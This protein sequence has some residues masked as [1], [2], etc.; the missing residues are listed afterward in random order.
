[1]RARAVFS[2]IVLLSACGGSKSTGSHD[3]G[4]SMD[5]STT[6]SPC[7]GVSGN[8]VPLMSAD[9][10]ANAF[11]TVKPNTT[12]AIAAGTYTFSISLNLANVSHVTIMGAGADKTVLDFSTQAAGSEGILAMDST[13]LTFSGFAVRD[14]PGDAI[15]VKSSTTVTFKNLEISWTG[16]DPHKHGAYG[17]YPVA[18]KNVLIDSNDVSGASDSG[19]YVGQSNMIIV[20][21]N[22]VKQ[23]VSG[24]EIEN[25]FY[26][27]V[28]GNDAEDNTAGIL[29]F[30]LPDL[31]QKGGH[32][33]RIFN[34]VIKHN[35]T[36]NFAAMGDIVGI[37]PAGT[38]F[39]VTA[40]HDV[41]AFN[42]MV[43]DNGT[44]AMSVIS[45]YITMMPIHDA[46][47]YPFPYNVYIHDNTLSGNG[48][49]PDMTN[50]IAQLLLTA[51]AVYP[52]MRIPDLLYDGVVDPT[53]Q[54]GAANNR[55]EIC[56]MN[57]GDATLANLH[58]DA[59]N[60]QG[61]NL[62]MIVSFDT[63]PYTCSLPA[64]P[65]VVLP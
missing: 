14:T 60:M 16:A 59:L 29:V 27:D 25:S 38:G 20:K 30:D 19:I 50:T 32:N 13:D 48:T 17:L 4:G 46:T 1:M 21:D 41:E 47:Y 57:N 64:L 26:A 15:K 3:G 5:A 22:T 56:F 2:M 23:N 33:V 34:N 28:M 43:L 55:M 62:P 9:D 58:L 63:G 31:Q 37:V 40:N 52:Q 35:N 12:L 53:H 61:T 45:Y 11:I 8:C 10:I 39:F 54:G 6:T 65:P 7:A 36:P 42:N 51:K 44:A 18:C 24:I 49:A